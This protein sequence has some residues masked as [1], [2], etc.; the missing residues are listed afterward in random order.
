MSETSKP[1]GEE[2]VAVTAKA[3]PHSA[4][5]EHLKEQMM[6]RELT[7]GEVIAIIEASIFEEFVEHT[8]PDLKAEIDNAE[9]GTDKT[10]ANTFIAVA[11]D[12]AKGWGHD[13]AV[14]MQRSGWLASTSRAVQ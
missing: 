8:L 2:I 5:I 10:N 13:L 6:D 4:W 12:F 14:Q 7:K 3:Y 9:P 11:A 1:G